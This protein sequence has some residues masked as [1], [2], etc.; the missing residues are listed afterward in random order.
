[1]SERERIARIVDPE[2]F[3]KLDA[4][5]VEREG[6]RLALMVWEI[7]EIVGPALAKADA[8]LARPEPSEAV[9]EAVA[10]EMCRHIGDDPDLQ[11][12]GGEA[13]WE[14]LAGHARAAIAAYEAE[15]LK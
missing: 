15:R 5:V 7:S 9:V 13:R 2:A 4:L 1:V 3:A 11:M 8:I 6:G 12:S 14:W 10:R